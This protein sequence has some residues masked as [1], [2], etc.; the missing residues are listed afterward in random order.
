MK[1]NSRGINQTVVICKCAQTKRGARPSE[2][3]QSQTDR[4]E[5]FLTSLTR[6]SLRIIRPAPLREEVETTAQK[7]LPKPLPPGQRQ[8]LDQQKLARN[9]PDA[10]ERTSLITLVRKPASAPPPLLPPRPLRG[11]R[12]AFGLPIQPKNPTPKPPAPPRALRS[13]PGTASTTRSQAA[14]SRRTGSTP[15]RHRARRRC[16]A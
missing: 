1:R 12:E 14:R 10:I 7:L 5:P 3:T 16:R 13:A 15:G 9:V 11:L 6:M 4:S 2:P 8:I